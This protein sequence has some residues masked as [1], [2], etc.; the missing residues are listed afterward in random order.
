MA[1]QGRTARR[2]YLLDYFW[3]HIAPILEARI[4]AKLTQERGSTT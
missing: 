3:T 2:E 1:K 4:E